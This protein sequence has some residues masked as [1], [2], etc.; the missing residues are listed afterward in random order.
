MTFKEQLSIRIHQLNSAEKLILINVVC[1]VLP[2]LIKT[3]LFLFNISSTNF[4]NWFEL[5]A[6]WI[7]LP[8]KPWSIITYS[9]LHSGFFHL[10]WNM[11]LLFFSS[12]LFLN[13][14]PSNTFFNVYFLGVVVGGITFILSYTFFPVFQN[15]SP[16]MIGASAGVMAVFIFMSTYSPD[17]EIR[18]ILFN[19]KLRYLGIAFLLLDIVQIPYGNAGGHLAHL[20]GAI[21]GFYYV[22]QLKNGKDIGK[23][24]KNFIDKIMN[25]FLR[26]PKMRTVYTREKSQ[27]I[28]KKVSDAGE[29]QKRIDRIL[30]KI[31]ISGYESLT[32]AEKDFLFKVGKS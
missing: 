9:F 25:I 30:D 23:P 3:V 31:S 11:Y 17:L 4:F 26:K 18:L 21:L 19:V 28:N 32:Q 6:S 14:F 15:S 13:L 20:G 5:S 24:F 10:F 1:F 12:K 29:K 27:K 8:T 22:K 2:M 16:V 7:D